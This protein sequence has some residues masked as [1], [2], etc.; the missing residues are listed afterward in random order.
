MF[1][2]QQFDRVPQ[3]EIHKICDTIKNNIFINDLAVKFNELFFRLIEYSL[4]DNKGVNDWVF[5]SSFIRVLHK[6]RDLTQYPTFKND[7]STF[8]EKFINE[9]KPYHTQIR[10][11]ISK[12]DGDDL[13][14]G[15]VTDFDVHSFWDTTLEYFRKPSGDFA[16]DE[17]CGH[18]TKINH[19]A[20]IED[21]I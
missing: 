9:V 16:G 5:K 4:H 15:D 3:I 11:Y 13:F 18:Q 12:F 8:I 7:N 2:L 20:I 14:L 10:E 1:D 21:I 6:L 19:G 17:L